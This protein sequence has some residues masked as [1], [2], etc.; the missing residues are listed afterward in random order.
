MKNI[1]LLISGS[2]LIKL[3]LISQA[4]L[5]TLDPE[6]RYPNGF[7][8]YSSLNE[9]VGLSSVCTGQ[10]SASPEGQARRCHLEVGPLGLLGVLTVTSGG[11]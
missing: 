8:G 10:T 7:S 1:S 11:N 6:H 2:L 9:Q 3:E 4:Q 5:E